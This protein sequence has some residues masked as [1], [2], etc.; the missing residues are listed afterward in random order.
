MSLSE[1]LGISPARSALQGRSLDTPTR[2]R[3]WS[4]F[5][6]LVPEASGRSFHQSWMGQLFAHVWS[7]FFRQPV[8]DMPLE[9]DAR[10]VI[11]RIFTEADWWKV[12]DLIEFVLGSPHNGNRE[13][14]KAAFSTILREEMAGFR[15]ID[16]LFVEITDETEIT[17]IESALVAT[18][19]DKFAAPRAHLTAALQLLSDRQAPDYRNSMKES[20]SAVESIVQVL[21]GDTQAELG[22]AIKLLG[23]KTPI[24][25]AFR[26]A[27]LSLYGYTS[28]A[29]GIRHALTDA[30]NLDAADAK[31]LL[32]ICSAF[33]VYLI[34][35]TATQ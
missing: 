5:A 9:R 6:L 32:V 31:F 21:T 15:Y 35:K 2:N 11:R 4:A 29:Q 8:D 24:H 28:D 20:I 22:K 23:A 25:G 33:V 1:R 12:Y 3:L 27:L 26:S 14:I 34:Q 16:G 30:S 18:L 13:K 19:G 10:T 7:D 17:A